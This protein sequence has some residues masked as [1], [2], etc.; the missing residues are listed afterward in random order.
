MKCS[1]RVEARPGEAAPLVELHRD[2]E[3]AARALLPDTD[4]SGQRPALERPPKPDLGDYSSNAAMLFAAAAGEAPRDLA[5]RL[6]DQL[7]SRLG[8]SADRIEVAGPGFINLFMSD[9]WYRRSLERL[10]AA[11]AAVERAPQTERVL[12]EFVSANPTGPLTAAGGR[13]AAYGDSVARMLEATGHEVQREY[14]VNDAGSQIERFAESVAARMRRA[15]PPDDGYEGE[16]VSELARQLADEGIDA[17]D[18]EAVARRAV[19]RMVELIG[20][21]LRRYGIEFDVWF[22]ERSL[23]DARAV[24]AAIDALRESSHVY[25]SEG[26]LWLRTT[27]F[28][29]DKD[30]VLVRSG[31][32]PT[33]FAADIAY[34]RDKLKRGAQRL[35]DVLGPDHHGYLARMRAAIEALGGN[36][37]SFEAKVIQLVNLVEGGERAQMSKRRGEFVTLDELIDDIGT[38]ATRFFMLQR[39]HDTALDLDLE[40]AR[41]QSNDNPV[42]YVQYAHARIASILRKACEDGD[43][44]AA[45]PDPSSR[46]LALEPAERML[47]KRMLELSDEVGEAAERR[48]PH[49]LCAY[50][51]AL[52]A[53]FHAFYRD[54]KVIDAEGDGVEES[55]LALCLLTKQTI[56]RTLDLL[57]IGAPERM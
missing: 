45:S 48:A 56:A 6:S 3:E 20:E 49:R 11:P 31:G 37:E 14:Y 46:T 9:S 52:A 53:D 30:R 35:I 29:D 13:H 5:G 41:E 2:V 26:A 57:G 43:G 12:V 18:L 17:S 15:D 25:E 42:Y 54:C 4:I 34:H 23:H 32:E 8:D 27:E 50:G 7:A 22:S 19:E 51:G 40:L 1:S 36:P 33:Y 39:S 38:D 47:L 10:A 28:G 21:T 24:D 44:R 55:R 16:Y